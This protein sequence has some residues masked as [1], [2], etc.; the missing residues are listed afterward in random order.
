MQRLNCINQIY[1][2]VL[3]IQTYIQELFAQTSM[4]HLHN[5]ETFL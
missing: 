5:N 2:K 1:F 4:L 3:S